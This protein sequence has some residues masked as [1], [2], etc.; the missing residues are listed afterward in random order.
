MKKAVYILLSLVILSTNLFV[1]SSF[2]NKQVSS[3]IYEK[4]KV[5]LNFKEGV[6]VEFSELLNHMSRFSAEHNINIMQYNFMSEKELNIYSTNIKY[7][8]DIHLIE[9]VLPKGESYISNKKNKYN[10]LC[11][12]FS[13][14]L[15]S[16]DIKI[17]DF[18]QVRNV[19][20][21]NRFYFNRLD[22]EVLDKFIEEFS[23]Y[24]KI[25]LL[26]ENI[27]MHSIINK[28]LLMIMIFTLV[29]FL[30]LIFYYHIYNR[31]EMVLYELWGYSKKDSYINLIRPFLNLFCYSLILLFIMLLLFITIFKQGFYIKEYFI[32]FIITNLVLG[33]ILTIILILAN[34]FIGRFSDCL[35][36]IKGKLSFKSIKIISIILKAITCIVMFIILGNSLIYYNNLKTKISNF[37]YWSKTEDVYKIVVGSLFTETVNN[38]KKD[39]DYNDRALAFYKE[40]KKKP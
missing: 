25:T 16:W 4:P 30:M 33:S 29:V 32:V 9:G 17:F 28:T 11:G 39:R 2:I 7:D 23:V 12:V 31:K 10:N 5:Q 37:D 34:F 22:K 1:Y 40:L 18:Q 13:F 3:L 14:P 35:G 24:A 36:G 19:G 8:D 15:S 38:Y 20:I 6:T 27:Y 21:G 26:N